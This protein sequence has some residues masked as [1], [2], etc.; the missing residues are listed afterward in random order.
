MPP[1]TPKRQEKYS[2]LTIYDDESA[3][4]PIL[5]ANLRRATLEYI[6]RVKI[7]KI[8]LNSDLQEYP[9]PIVLTSPE[10]IR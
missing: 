3:T 5:I 6:E 10:L 2:V 8:Q 4:R 7:I 1:K 9:D